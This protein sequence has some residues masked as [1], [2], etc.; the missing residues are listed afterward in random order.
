MCARAPE[1]H[2]EGNGTEIGARSCCSK[3]A[4]DTRSFVEVLGFVYV[5]IFGGSRCEGPTL[6]ARAQWTADQSS[7]PGKGCFFLLPGPKD[8]FFWATRV[9]KVTFAARGAFGC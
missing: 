3:S 4:V 7:G 9:E 6:C 5:S 1:V 2:L 8:Y